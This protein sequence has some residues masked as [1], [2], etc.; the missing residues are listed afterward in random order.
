MAISGHSQPRPCPVGGAGRRSV[1]RRGGTIAPG[2]SQRWWS[3]VGVPCY[4]NGRGGG[5]GSIGA[6]PRHD[7]RRR[8][9]RM[10]VTR[11]PRRPSASRFRRRHS[12]HHR[13]VATTPAAAAAKAGSPELCHRARCRRNVTYTAALRSAPLP[14][15]TRSGAL[16][17]NGRPPPPPAHSIRRAPALPRVVPRPPTHPR[18]RFDARQRSRVP[19]QLR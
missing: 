15:Q 7:P 19:V 13:R 11:R 9:G 6:S 18:V 16:A 8:A 14:A 10:L 12:G 2:G 4:V 3:P 17:R 1:H 5:W